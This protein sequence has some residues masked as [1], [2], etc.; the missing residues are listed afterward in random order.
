MRVGEETRSVSGFQDRTLIRPS[1]RT[2]AHS[3]LWGEGFGSVQIGRN[4]DLCGTFGYIYWELGQSA[5]VWRAGGPVCRPYGGNVVS[6]GGAPCR[7]VCGRRAGG[8]TRPY[9]DCGRKTAG[10]QCAPL[11][12]HYKR[13]RTQEKGQVLDL[14]LKTQRRSEA[15][16]KISLLTFFFKESKTGRWRGG[17]GGPPDAP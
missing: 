13:L 9:G 7:V 5:P 8:D 14:S 11:Q 4:L 2:G 1:V 3:P 12:R 17:R 10:A 6:P 15:S 16:Q